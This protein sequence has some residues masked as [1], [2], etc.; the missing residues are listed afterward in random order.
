M[1]GLRDGFQMA[2]D[3]GA[4]VV[5]PGKASSGHTLPAPS[6]LFLTAG[7]LAAAR[8]IEAHRTPFAFESH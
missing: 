4:Q 1:P 5:A 7:S 8:P 6:F 3:E 2:A